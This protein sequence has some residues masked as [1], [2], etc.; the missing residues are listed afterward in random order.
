MLKSC[1]SNTNARPNTQLLSLCRFIATNYSSEIAPEGQ[2]PA[3]A[4]HEMQV[5]AS[6]S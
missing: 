2:V 6:I 4:P 5:S 1:I 3:Q